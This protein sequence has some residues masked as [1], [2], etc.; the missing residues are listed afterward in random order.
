MTFLRH[1]RLVMRMFYDFR[2]GV[3][4]GGEASGVVGEAVLA[5]EIGAAY[6]KSISAWNRRVEG[7]SGAGRGGRRKIEGWKRCSPLEIPSL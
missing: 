3:F 5:P 4:G 6:Q 1:F 7:G 2:V